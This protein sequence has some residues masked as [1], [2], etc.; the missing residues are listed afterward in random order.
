MN[1]RII[2]DT[3]SSLF[4]H[5]TVAAQSVSSKKPPSRVPSVTGP[6]ASNVPPSLVNSKIATS[7]EKKQNASVVVSRAAAQKAPSNVGSKA[8][9]RS[10]QT[11]V[12]RH[13][14]S[15][16]EGLLTKEREERAIAAQCLASTQKELDALEQLLSLRTAQAQSFPIPKTPS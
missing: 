3:S 8:E 13:Q 1:D 10:T 14:L 7:V 4:S 2:D 11:S 12:I 9:A 16:L 15:Q 6:P 5:T